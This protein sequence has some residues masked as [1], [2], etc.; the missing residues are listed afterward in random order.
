MAEENQRDRA[1][2]KEEI[3]KDRATFKTE[4]QSRDHAHN[5]TLSQI[6]SKIDENKQS[7]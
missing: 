3:L 7:S 6:L 4:M 1:E 5:E 2:L